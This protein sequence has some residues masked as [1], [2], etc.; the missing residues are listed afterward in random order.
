MRQCPCSPPHHA[1]GTTSASVAPLRA[2]LLALERHCPYLRKY[3][4]K[5]FAEP[6][7]QGRSKSVV[8]PCIVPTSY[9][10]SGL[11]R[12]SNSVMVHSGTIGSLSSCPRSSVA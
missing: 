7:L 5:R 6:R 4:I 12:A 3:T 10:P 1:P 2:L 8:Y 11:G 9:V